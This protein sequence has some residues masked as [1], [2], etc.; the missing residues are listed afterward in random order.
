LL[1]L[2]KAVALSGAGLDLETIQRGPQSNG[3]PLQGRASVDDR[4]STQR[5]SAMQGAPRVHRRRN[6][7]WIVAYNGDGVTHIGKL[8]AVPTR[9]DL[10]CAASR[11]Q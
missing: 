10:D 9:T 7:S 4:E 6:G 8:T 5:L 11:A 2:V 1:S 3:F